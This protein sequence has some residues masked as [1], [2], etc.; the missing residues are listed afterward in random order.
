MD[1]SDA[2]ADLP[3]FE[4][5]GTSHVSAIIAT[6]AVALLLV[7]AARL[8][9]DS[10][11]LR[12]LEKVLAVLLLL[13]FP[14][15]L[16]FWTRDGALTPHNA[17]PLHL[18]NITAVLVALALLRHHR[19][20]AALSYFWGCAGAMQGLLTPALEAGFPRGSFLVFFLLHGGII[21]AGLHLV[22]GRRLVPRYRDVWVAAFFLIVYLIV[23]FPANLLLGTNYGFLHHKPETGS[24]LD[25]LGPWP[26]YIASIL[27]V[28]ILAFHLLYLPTRLLRAN[29]ENP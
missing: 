18:C 17:Y 1:A 21:A 8:R 16:Y 9:P 27:G 5:F 10:F 23:V 29:S 28:S 24:L 20:L 4:A 12:H 6:V 19:G 22:F 26:L 15:N 2:P 11:N 25:H 14:L 13:T 7:F 3:T